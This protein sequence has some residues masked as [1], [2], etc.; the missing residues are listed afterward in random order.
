VTWL[1]PPRAALAAVG[2]YFLVSAVV[3]TVLGPF[4]YSLPRYGT[5][6]YPPELTL[7]AVAT[8]AGVAVAAAVAY[9]RGGM[10]AYAIVALLQAAVAASAILPAVEQGLGWS[11]LVPPRDLV[12][13][14][15]FAALVLSELP[16]LAALAVGL[17]FA[18]RFLR[19]AGPAPALEAAGAYC[20]TAVALV[21]PKPV[22]DVRSVPFQASFMLS[23][24]W[25]VI[26]TFVPAVVAGLV[27]AS[28]ERPLWRTAAIAT[29][30]G[31]AGAAPVAI[32]ML[33]TIG[34]PVVPVL[35]FLVPLATAG[36]AVALTLMRPWTA[37][38]LSAL[39][40]RVSLRSRLAA[41]AI[42][43]A[44]AATALMGAVVAL[45]ELP[46][47]YDYLAPLDGTYQRTGDERKFVVTATL[48]RGV[49]IVR[50]SAKEDPSR[51]VVSVRA[52][53]RPSWGFSD[54]VGIPVPVVVTLRD[55][56][57]ERAVIDGRHGAR[58]LDEAV[59]AQQEVG[60]IE[61]ASVRT[62][63][64]T[65][66]FRWTDS[67]GTHSVAELR[68]QT[69]VIVNRDGHSNDAKISVG[70]LESYVAKASTADRAR[71]LVL[72]V[73]FDRRL[74]YPSRDEVV[75]T[76]FV[77]PGEVPSDAPEILREAGVPA[78]WVIGPDGR[79]RERIVGR[80]ASDADVAR[81]L[82]PAR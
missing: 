18:M 55:S 64:T 34:G 15:P 77:P 7:L 11:S 19:R 81:A 44:V 32:L 30:I 36:V 54:L 29:L 52:R 58:L 27:L 39:D 14:T 47:G 70:A 71:V 49:D 20:L 56:L 22:L 51:V 26:A 66:D 65:I 42:G 4:R 1:T 45:A 5:I 38:S 50:V 67:K 69:V 78:L 31:L 76:L 10:R 80:A 60:V 16:A 62:S 79:V 2:A 59:L 37:R 21:L 33:T 9:A 75:R 23:G 28:H 61:G 24:E 72:V 73:H 53:S 40:R 17:A 35:P 12:G 48:G 68:G 63:P 3:L 13:L 6:Y 43:G 57:R 46:T 74:A 8:A 41:A 82:A 25:Y